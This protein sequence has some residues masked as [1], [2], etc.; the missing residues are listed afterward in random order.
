MHFCG[1]ILEGEHVV[2][3]DVEGDFRIS[4]RRGG[5]QYWEGQLY[6]PPDAAIYDGG[7][8]T[9]R[10]DDGREGEIL[11]GGGP[12]ISAR[13]NSFAFKGNGRPP[14]GSQNGLP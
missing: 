10:L 13:R 1:I 3:P 5:T 2:A 12:Y 9:L 4:T 11:V 6:V 7:T 14:S 8:Y